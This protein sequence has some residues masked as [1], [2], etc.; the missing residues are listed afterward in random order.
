MTTLR[1]LEV[2]SIERILEVF[3]LSFSDYLIPLR[4]TK[5]Q[6][7][8]KVKS[9]SIK[10]ELSVG[11]FDDGQLVALILHGYDVVDNLKVVYNAGTGV[12]PT[13]RGNGLTA[14]LYEYVLPIFYKNDIDKILLQVITTNA[15]AIKIYKS[16]GFSIVK[17]VDC[18][19]GS[20]A[21]SKSINDFEISP[22]LFYDWQVLKSFWDL[23]PLW[24]NSITA[25]EKLKDSNVSIGVFEHGE[26]LGYA[27][28]NP[29]IKRIHQIAVHKNHRKRGVGLR[30]VKH[31]STLNT[32]GVSVLNIDHSS[33]DILKFMTN[34]GLKVF[35]KQ[36][37]MELNLK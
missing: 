25:V 26:L 30:L 34:I 37:E 2:T 8:D 3:N 33:K 15:V 14:K 21:I 6:F 18:F 1:T 4:L 29:V 27:I 35:I 28:Y 22:L 32:E 11:A 7:E 13:K 17:E 9:E 24:Q 5:E 20:L 19:K 36:Y 12:I 23:E 10:L 16:I 31:I